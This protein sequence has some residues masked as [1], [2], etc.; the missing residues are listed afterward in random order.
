MQTLPLAVPV[1]PDIAQAFL[2]SSD[3]DR[4]KIE[5]ILGLHLE[6]LVA[7]RGQT[8]REVMDEMGR[9]AAANGMTPEILQSILD[10]E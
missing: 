5:W 8:L 9:E 2:A 4:R 3:D 6:R 1:N 7:S 10:D